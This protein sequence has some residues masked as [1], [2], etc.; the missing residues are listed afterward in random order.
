MDACLGNTECAEFDK[1]IRF[2]LWEIILSE[3]VTGNALGVDRM[4][5]L[6]RDSHH[7]GVAYGKKEALR[8]TNRQ[9][10]KVLWFRNPTDK[11]KNAGAIDCIYKA[12]VTKFGTDNLRKDAYQKNKGASSFPVE[13]DNGRIADAKAASDT[14]SK[15]PFDNLEFIF[16]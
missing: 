16:R 5:Y 3:I 13:L 10:F 1:S 15:I 8:I 2:D 12:A 6:L 7:A 4:D 9:H 14:L 11:A